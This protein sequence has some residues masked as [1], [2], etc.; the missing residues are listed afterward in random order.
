MR[1]RQHPQ[2]VD[3]PPGPGGTNVRAESPQAAS[4]AVITEVHICSVLDKA[5]PLTGQFKGNPF[6]YD[7]L[8]KEHAFARRL[9]E[10]FSRHIGCT[11]EQLGDLNVDF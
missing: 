7:V 9:A 1:V 3:W 6:T 5:I 11:L 10:E 8:T 4:Q 2:V